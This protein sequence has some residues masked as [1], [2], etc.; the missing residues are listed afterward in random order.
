MGNKMIQNLHNVS[1]IENYPE[2]AYYG[3]YVI[4]TVKHCFYAILGENNLSA[5]LFYPNNC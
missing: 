3:P 5:Q 2:N 1:F 4:T